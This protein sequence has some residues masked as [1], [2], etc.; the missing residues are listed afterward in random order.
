MKKTI[1]SLILMFVMVGPVFA[2]DVDVDIDY[3][4]RNPFNYFT[5][6][7]VT[8]GRSPVERERIVTERI[9]SRARYRRECWERRHHHHH[10][11]HDDFDRDHD[12]DH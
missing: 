11:D 2:D 8:I 4:H 1:I 6:W 5:D 7:S 12:R 3:H 10:H 9:E